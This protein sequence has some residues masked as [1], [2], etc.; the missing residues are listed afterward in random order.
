MSTTRPDFGVPVREFNHHQD[1]G[2]RVDPFT[3]FDRF[4]DDPIFWSPEFDGFWVLTRFEDIRSVLRDGETFA[5]RHTLIPPVEWPG[6]RSKRAPRESADW[7]SYRILLVR[8][9][10]GPAGAAVTNAVRRAGARLVADIAPRG[11]CDLVAD[12]A[13]PLRDALFG[14]LFDVPESETQRCAR[15]AVDLLQDGDPDRRVRAAKDFMG[16]VGA[17]I[18]ACA[19]GSRTGTGLLH[20]LATA[21][22]DGRPLRAEEAVDLAF[23]M[24]IGAVDTITNSVAFSFRYLAG[25]P[26]LQR[27]IATESD[28]A[29]NAADELLRLHSVASVARTA[30]RD[31]EIAGVRIREGERVLLSFALADR[32]P[33]EYPEPATADFDR[34]NRAGHLAFGSGAHRCVGARLAT[35]GLAVALREWH[36]VIRDYAN[37]AGARPRTGGGAV[38]SVDTLPLTWP[39]PPGE[40]LSAVSAANETNGTGND[41]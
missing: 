31:T 5:S 11:E 14:A 37:A 7:S 34:P 12:F 9:V 20:A 4:R 39:V 22:V 38:F 40:E 15:W 18:A 1:P 36:A 33:H 3:A 8:S 25:H 10:T 6:E 13:R 28:A 23:K 35:Q 2:L 32:D 30:T 21:E 17:G 16:Y 29:V 19:S 41:L 27:R 26:H 24:G